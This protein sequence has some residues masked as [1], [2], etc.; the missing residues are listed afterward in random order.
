MNFL[1]Y[2]RILRSTDP[3]TLS[4]IVYLDGTPSF[5]SVAIV[6]I[7]GE[8]IELYCAHPIWNLEKDLEV[9]KVSELCKTKEWEF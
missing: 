3:I 2:K 8:C 1:Y 5:T 6:G 7:T 9:N 4:R